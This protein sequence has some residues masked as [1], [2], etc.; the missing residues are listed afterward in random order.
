[1]ADILYFV[2][3]ILQ[4][5]AYGIVVYHFIISLF[6]WRNKPQK[7][8]TENNIY[9][10]AVLISA[11]NEENV[12]SEALKSI[13]SVNYDKNYFDV[14][15]IA[16]NCTDSTADIAEKSGAVVWRRNNRLQTG[17]GYALKWA[18]NRLYSYENKYDAVC[19][20]DADN[21]MHEDFLTNINAEF[22]RGYDSVQGY[23]DAK[24]P[25]DSW[26]TASYYIT[27][28]CV[29]KMYQKARHNIGFPVQLNGTGFAV[30]TELLR[31][32]R[33]DPSCLTEDIE[34]TMEMAQ[35]N[36]FTAY[37]ERAVVY[38]EKP[39]ELIT[40][41]KQRTR[42]MQGQS[43]SAFRYFIPL[44][45]TVN[46]LKMLDCIIYLLQPVFF[47]VTGLLTVMGIFQ[48]FITKIKFLYV[49]FAGTYAGS[50][51]LAFQICYV[52]IVLFMTGRLNTKTM[53]YYI[54]YL[55]FM[56]TWIPVSL[57]GM[58]NRKKKAW[59]HTKHTVRI[60]NQ[61]TDTLRF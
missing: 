12:I 31:N 22:N 46:P 40:S 48:F 54:P 6:A 30:K 57:A 2:S 29:N 51:M 58:I 3:I 24:N 44:M 16:D 37:C 25:F 42:W 56:Y 4:I 10:F 59:F 60:K 7:S 55:A 45:K 1:M 49:P 33:W 43:D 17:K 39:V 35:K 50:I 14:F 5:Y 32:L 8:G 18:L 9:R 21:I 61:K 52:P 27:L 19:I 26:V 28:V 20:M 34:M 15:V 53:L 13:F 23:I 38:D 36:I 11:H 47:T 41:L